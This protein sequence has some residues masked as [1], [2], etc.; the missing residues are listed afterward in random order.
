MRH[1][2]NVILIAF[3]LSRPLKV[4]FNGAVTQILH[5]DNWTISEIKTLLHPP[6]VWQGLTGWLA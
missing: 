4:T 6:K 1:K 2:D 3:D 5:T